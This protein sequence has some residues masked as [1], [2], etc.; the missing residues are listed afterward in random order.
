[1]T[2]GSGSG[3]GRGRA[4]TGSGAWGNTGA[5]PKIRRAGSTGG[6]LAGTGGK[7]SSRSGEE[8]A[9]GAT[10]LTPVTLTVG[11]V[12]GAL[13]KAF[14][15]SSG[16]SPNPGNGT[17]PV[18]KG[19]R[20]GTAT[21]ASA[22]S[23]RLW[24]KLPSLGG[25]ALGCRKRPSPA[26][27]SKNQPKV[28][29]AAANKPKEA[30]PAGVHSPAKGCSSAG[31]AL[32]ISSSGSGATGTVALATGA[33]RGSVGS[34]GSAGGGVRFSKRRG[35]SMVGSARGTVRVDDRYTDS[36]AIRPRARQVL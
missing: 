27:S 8:V 7:S 16:R 17:K 24:G 36:V 12:A 9:G 26:G 25:G 29:L 35:K 6:A 34:S 21:V 20:T 32:S 14:W 1:M 28:K 4:T 5:A 11:V 15:D 18:G 31:D 19:S 22:G 23:E 30:I 3:T 2:T 33:T 13:V 10:G